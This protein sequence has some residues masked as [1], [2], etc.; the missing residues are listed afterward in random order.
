MMDARR[1]RLARE[2]RVPVLVFSIHKP[3]AFADVLAG[4]GLYTIIEERE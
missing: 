4:R 1:S 2:N 3:G